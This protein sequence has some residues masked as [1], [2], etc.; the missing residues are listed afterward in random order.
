MAT[1]K[2]TYTSY[3]K[4]KGAHEK[5][6]TLHKGTFEQC[7][8]YVKDNYQVILSKEN[9]E[10]RIPGLLYPSMIKITGK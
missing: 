10:T 3:S 5:N 6:L 9:K 4:K 8:D 1:V 2:K 7:V